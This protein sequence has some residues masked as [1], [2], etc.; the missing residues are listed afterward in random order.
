MIKDYYDKAID[1]SQ[2]KVKSNYHTH[3]YMCGHAGGTVIDYVKH[4][5]EHGF[6]VLGISDH[7]RTPIGTGEP[8]MTQ[9]TLRTEYMPQ[10]DEARAEYGDKIK[11]LSAVEIE[12]FSGYDDYYDELLE[13]LDYLVLGQHEYLLD[14]ARKNSFWDGVDDENIVAYCDS[15]IAAIQSG[16]FAMIAHPDLIFYDR[17]ELTPRMKSAFEALVRTAEKA[18]VV[19]EL[20]A[21]GVRYHHFNYPT[22]L[23]I[24][25]CKKYNAPVIVSSDA[26]VPHCLT[27]KY[28][29]ELYGYAKT[30]GLNVIDYL[31]I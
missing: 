6:E 4:A 7:C 31:K 21:N 27:D 18:G 15:V 23:L 16:R 29:Y 22:D 8:Y 1:I 24:A 26:H 30:H 11:I 28:V 17:P 5:V 13:N 14:G 20:N 25:L 2:F 10:F 19:L 3:N 9:K 12:Y